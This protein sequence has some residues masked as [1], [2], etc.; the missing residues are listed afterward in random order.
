[1]NIQQAIAAPRVSFY[2]PDSLA[3]ETTVSADVR[4][5]LSEMGHNVGVTRGLG[6]AHGLVIEYDNLGRPIRF[7]GGADP[8][9]AGSAKGR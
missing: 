9:G 7:Y 2:E 5:A 1:M 6:N 3:V 8:R 4:R